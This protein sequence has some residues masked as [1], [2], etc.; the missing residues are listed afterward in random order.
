MADLANK[1]QVTRG[2][3]DPTT[4]Q[5]FTGDRLLERV[6]QKHFGGDS[7]VWMGEAPIH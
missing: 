2:Q 4:G 6:A 1:I 7:A 3:I 5:P